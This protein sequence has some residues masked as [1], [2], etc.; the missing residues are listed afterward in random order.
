[1]KRREFLELSGIA[2]ILATGRAPAFAQARSIHLLQWSHFVPAADTLFEA[3]ARE[4]GKQAGVEVKIERINTGN[5]PSIYIA[6][7]Q[8]FP[9]VYKGT[10]HGHYPPGPAGRIDWVPC[11]NSC[12]MKY[13]RN[14]NLAKDFI[15]FYMDRPQFDRY[16]ET[17]DTFGIPATRAYADHPLWRKDPRTAVFPEMLRHARQVDY[18]GPPGR[19]AT[20]V[21]SKSIIVDMFA[22]AIQGMRPED[23]V[24]WAA[25]ELTK[26][27]TA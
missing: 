18:A 1:M 14:I 13:S 12:V 16:F 4:F 3:Q 27:Y 23:A 17:M 20:E 9:D 19:K 11:W 22:E 6:A 21:L 15:R 10:N 25:A 26:I 7:R 24:A 5:A 2:G 8:K